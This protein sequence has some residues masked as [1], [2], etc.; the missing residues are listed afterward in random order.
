MKKYKKSFKTRRKKSLGREVKKAFGSKLFLA[1][2]VL[3]IAI[4]SLAYLFLLSSVFKIKNMEFSGCQKTSC[5]ELKSIVYENTSKNIFLSDIANAAKI[6]REKYPV[7]SDISIKRKLPDKISAKIEER[8]PVIALSFLSEFYF[9]DKEGVVFEESQDIPF[10]IPE[11]KDESL[12]NDIKLGE[13]IIK[14]KDIENILKIEGGLSGSLKIIVRE[15]SMASP[16]KIS[17]ITEEGW[18]AY[19][20]P[21]KDLDWQIEQ[22]GIILKEKIPQESRR[23]IE[24]IDLR[25]DKI[26]I[27]PE[28]Y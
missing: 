16:K 2:I 7:V 10:G 21:E 3:T 11:I 19:L 24:Y 13:T 9:I 17:V 22:L 14:K 8:Q 1:G 18:K 5:D 23:N 20:N 4:S 15:I 28:N 25:F 26:Y 27:F 6:I 12:K